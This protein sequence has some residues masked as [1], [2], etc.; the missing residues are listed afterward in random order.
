MLFAGSGGGGGVHVAGLRE[1]C[2]AMVDYNHWSTVCGRHE[3][4]IYMEIQSHW[5][6]EEVSLC[7]ALG[8]DFM[9]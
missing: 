8:R 7:P 1:S 4:G 2:Q 3:E 6:E 5:G 9:A